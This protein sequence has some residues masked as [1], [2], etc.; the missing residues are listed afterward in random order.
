[1]Y[2]HRVALGLG[3]LLACAS[4]ATYHDQLARG[5]HAFEDSQYDRTLAILRDLE[6]DVKRLT[7][8][9]QA[10]YA[11]LRGI[12][13]YRVGYKPDARHWLAVAK[14]Y[15]DNSP[16]VLTADWK[17]RVNESLEA[18]NGVVYAA[19]TTALVTARVEEAPATDEDSQKADRDKSERRGHR[20]S[21]DKRN[22]HD[23]KKDR[24]QPKDAATPPP[25]VKAAEPATKAADPASK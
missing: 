9:E 1:M 2:V 25:A 19:G 12:A 18:M 10:Q 6:P 7:V 22:A 11:Y 3:L 21:Q 16:G 4:C 15:E 20:G 24:G 8:P 17:A 14:A 23:Q 13:D 5:Q